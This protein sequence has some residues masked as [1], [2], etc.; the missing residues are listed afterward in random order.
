M[1]KQECVN[2]ERD[3]I[4]SQVPEAGLKSKHNPKTEDQNGYK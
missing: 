2:S 1:K 3:N 4:F